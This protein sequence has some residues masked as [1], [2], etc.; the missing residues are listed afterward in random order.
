MLAVEDADFYEHDG[1]SAKSVVRALRAN[2]D[3][4]RSPRAAPPSPS[5][6][7]RSPWSATSAASPASSRR[8]RSPSSWRTSCARACPRSPARTGSWSSTSTP[9]TW[10]VAPTA[11]RPR[12]RP[13]STSPRRRS[14]TRRPPS[15]P[16]WCGTRPATTPSSTRRWRRSGAGWCSSGWWS[17]TCSPRT[18][19]PSSRPRPCPPRPTAGP[20]PPPRSRSATWSA[21]SVTSCSRP[22]GWPP[23]RSSAATWSSTAACA[24]PPPSTP[25]HR[26]W[27]RRPRP[28]TR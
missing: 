2:S 24:S 12:R 20:R 18:R 3:A 26:P 28:P 10:V 5:S 19:P 21:R 27:P 16:P 1:V 15:S 6:W 7:S 17:R 23:P 14:T 13:T 9:C 25:G 4:G 22:S 11:C 8:P